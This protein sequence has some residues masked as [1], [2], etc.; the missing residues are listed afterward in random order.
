MIIATPRYLRMRSCLSK[1]ALSC[2]VLFHPS[3]LLLFT[4]RSR[5]KHVAVP[6]HLHATALTVGTFPV[7]CTHNIA[8]LVCTLVEHHTTLTLQ[9]RF[10]LLVLAAKTWGDDKAVRLIMKLAV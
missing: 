1:A 6:P 5:Q 3:L 10:S 2:A 8:I 7:R 4:N 9:V